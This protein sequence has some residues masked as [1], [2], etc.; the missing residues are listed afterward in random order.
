L[1][2]GRARSLGTEVASSR[3][4]LCNCCPRRHRRFRQHRG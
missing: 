1:S 4:F 2:R 3:R